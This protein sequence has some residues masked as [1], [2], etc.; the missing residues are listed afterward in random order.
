M[1]DCGVWSNNPIQ[2]PNLHHK[3]PNERCYS[4]FYFVW[5]GFELSKTLDKLYFKRF[6]P[7]HAEFI[8]AS[9]KLVDLLLADKVLKQV[10]DDRNVSLFV[11]VNYIFSF[12]KPKQII[13]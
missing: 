4:V 11:C 3:K 6:I 12:K 10:Q 8:S 5:V 7:C 1:N 2:S 13:F 9:Y